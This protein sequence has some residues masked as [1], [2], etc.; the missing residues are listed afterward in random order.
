MPCS[1]LADLAV[2]AHVLFVIFVVCGGVAVLRWPRLARLHLPAVVWGVA[3]ELTGWVCPLTYLENRFRRQGGEA[4]YGGS[5]IQHYL[6]PLLYPLWLTPRLQVIMGL[7]VVA[8]N[9]A[10]YVRLWR[11]SPRNGG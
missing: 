9:A 1:L 11:K 10:I 3:I 7:G 5:F 8:I 6:E 4:G 2:V